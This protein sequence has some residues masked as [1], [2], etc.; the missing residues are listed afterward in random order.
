[1]KHIQ[2]LGD[3]SQEE[4]F[5][6][7]NMGMGFVLIA[8]EKDAEQIIQDLPDSFMAGRICD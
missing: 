6:V 7:W 2:K 8:D 4:A 5:T 1:M 3:I